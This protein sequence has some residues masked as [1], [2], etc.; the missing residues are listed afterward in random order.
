MSQE[1]EGAPLNAHNCEQQV[2]RAHFLDKN[3]KAK[4]GRITYPDIWKQEIKKKKTTNP[5]AI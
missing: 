3:T 5:Q 2:C 4:K 1:W